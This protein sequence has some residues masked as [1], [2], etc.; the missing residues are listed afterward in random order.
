MAPVGGT[1]EERYWLYISHGWCACLLPGLGH[2]S[3][4]KNATIKPELT[5]HGWRV[6]SA[7]SRALFENV[8][9]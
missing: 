4:G 5:I 9:R 8:S 3:F 1:A 6:R 2:Q 7:L